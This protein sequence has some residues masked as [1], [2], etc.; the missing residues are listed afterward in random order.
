MS[1]KYV[2]IDEYEKQILEQKRA[3]KYPPN[4]TMSFLDLSKVRK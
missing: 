4:E 2:K 3:G 1:R